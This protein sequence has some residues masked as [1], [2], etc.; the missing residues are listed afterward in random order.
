[1]GKLSEDQIERLLEDISLIKSVIN[2]NRP[3]LQQV[4]M[5]A[6]FR[7]LFLAVGLSIIIFC[8]AVHF[9][10]MRYGGYGGIP[11]MIKIILVICL[12]A[13]VL[14]LIVLRTTGVWGFLRKTDENPAL[15]GS[16]DA[17]FSSRLTHVFIPLVVLT[18]LIGIYAA[19]HG[20]VYYIV[21]IIS[22][23][24][25]LL[26]NVFASMTEIRQWLLS[27]YWFLGAGVM[28][29]GFPMP[30]PIAVAVSLGCGL[31]L[32]S[33]LGYFSAAPGIEE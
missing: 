11:G 4:L 27:G 31:L 30:T 28:T 16:L 5:P 25:G 17:F 15:R 19:T 12:L 22:M 20:G 26:Y 14:F 29:L 33:V 9:L 8:L 6:R 24:L 21:P 32:F 7:F 10:G 13:D 23:G 2:K 18:I 1:M 3:L